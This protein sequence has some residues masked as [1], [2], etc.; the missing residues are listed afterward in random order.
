M[1][2]ILPQRPIPLPNSSPDEGGPSSSVVTPS[3]SETED[4]ARRNTMLDV[5]CHLA[6]IAGE[7]AALFTSYG[8]TLEECRALKEERAEVQKVA[9]AE[10]EQERRLVERLMAYVPIAEDS[11]CLQDQST[12]ALLRQIVP[13][14]ERLVQDNKQRRAALVRKT[15][16]ADQFQMLCQLWEEYA[17]P[18]WAWIRHNEPFEK[19]CTWALSSLFRLVADRERILDRAE[20]LRHEIE[21]KTAT[22]KEYANV[23]MWKNGGEEW[24]RGWRG[25]GHGYALAQY[26]LQ[27]FEEPV[28][29]SLPKKE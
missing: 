3:S 16:Q 2:K 12:A 24:D 9:T 1:L 14:I 20:A 4:T 10:G 19:W 6:Q 27:K 25:Q 22:L 28:D 7:I 18:S 21:A 23:S 11:P 5:S 29:S 8:H 15:V 17:P 26:V 13:A